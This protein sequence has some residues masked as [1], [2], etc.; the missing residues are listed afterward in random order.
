MCNAQP[1][2]GSA[3]G[4]KIH[5]NM[6]SAGQPGSGSPVDG[7]GWEIFLCASNVLRACVCSCVSTLTHQHT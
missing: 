4:Y 5:D 1:A 7:V 6:S 3:A 2:N